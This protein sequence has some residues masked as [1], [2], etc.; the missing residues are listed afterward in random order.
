MPL[1]RADVHGEHVSTFALDVYWVS[2]KQGDPSLDVHVASCERCRDYLAGLD[3]VAATSPSV[4]MPVARSPSRGRASRWALP[5]AGALA[6]AAVVTLLVRGR[7]PESDGYVGIKGTPAVQVLLHRNNDTHL[8]DGH[9]PVHPGDA[10]ALRVACEGLKRVAVA[11]PGPGEGWVRLSSLG[12]PAH[13]EP[14]PFTLQVD[15]RPGDEKLAV[16][17]SQ[18]ELDE[19]ALQK[20]IADTRRTADIWVVSYVFTKETSR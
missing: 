6:L 13:D 10:L 18:E 9:S 4:S 1:D 15:D 12:C 14:L 5:V 16:V 20:A 11:T 19:D 2:G 3:A 17:M 8:W 7:P